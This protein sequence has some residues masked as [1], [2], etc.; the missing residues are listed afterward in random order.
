LEA[1]RE[2]LPNFDG[3][4]IKKTPAIFIPAGVERAKVPVDPALKI[5]ARF[6]ELG[7]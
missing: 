3:K 1:Q 7:S 4:T 6:G 2:Y 5:N